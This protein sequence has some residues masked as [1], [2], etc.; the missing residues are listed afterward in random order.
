MSVVQFS[1]ARAAAFAKE[2]AWIDTEYEA[3]REKIFNWPQKWFDDETSHCLALA[4]G[5][6]I[7]RKLRLIGC[8][9]AAKKYGADPT[10]FEAELRNE[11]LVEDSA[12]MMDTISDL[13][14]CSRMEIG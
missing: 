6:R 9:T 3:R 13:I 4:Q 14:T 5:H 8:I 10:C 7:I 12:K 1:E 2:L 11:N